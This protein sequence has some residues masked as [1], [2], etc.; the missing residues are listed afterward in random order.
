M[1]SI[2]LQER[3]GRTA[4][5]GGHW[6]GTGRSAGPGRRRRSRVRRLVRES[7]GFPAPAEIRAAPSRTGG[8]GELAG[9]GG[10]RR[11]ARPWPAVGKPR[12]ARRGYGHGQGE[13]SHPILQYGSIRIMHQHVYGRLL[14]S[15]HLGCTGPS[16]P[17]PRPTCFSTSR[18]N[19]SAHRLL[20]FPEN[21][22]RQTKPTRNLLLCRLPSQT[23]PASSLLSPLGLAAGRWPLDPELRRAAVVFR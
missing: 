6:V 22:H 9:V 11:A 19:S 14:G 3:S 20:L 7:S 15:A 5:P 12:R 10:R 1:P 21:P 17:P 8:P 13:S 18:P 16:H 4:T 23:K 2:C